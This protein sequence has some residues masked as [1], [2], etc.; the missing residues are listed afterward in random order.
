MQVPARLAPATH[1]DAV[2]AES[3]C[4]AFVSLPR[5]GAGERRNGNRP[6]FLPTMGGGSPDAAS[7]FWRQSRQIEAGRQASLPE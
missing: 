6:Y 7:P 3:L 2:P 4:G 1:D 5:L